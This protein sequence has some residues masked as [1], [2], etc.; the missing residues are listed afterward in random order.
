MIRS[1]A[2]IEPAD[3][4]RYTLDGD[5][6]VEN[7]IARDQQLIGKAVEDFLP[8]SLFR[9]LVLIGGYARA[10]G[11]FC[12]VDG[13]PMPY[14]DY[15]YFVVVKGANK[16]K[17]CALEPGL[18]R[19][20]QELEKQVGI[21][22][23]FFFLP[24]EELADAPCT[25]MFAE[26]QWGHAVVAGDPDVLAVMPPMPFASLPLS[27]FTR[28]MLNRGALLLMN[29]VM[30]MHGGPEDALQQEVFVKYL[31]KATLA[32][33]D[34]HLAARHI[35]HPSYPEKMRRLESMAGDEG[36]VALRDLYR[37]ALDARFHPDYG[38]YRDID[39]DEWQQ[40]VT[41]HWL[42]AMEILESARLPQP[43]CDWVS[44]ASHT[45]V[46]GQSDDT[47]TAIVRNLAVTARDYGLQELLI[48]PGWARRYPRE[49]LISVLPLLLQKGAEEHLADIC[50]VLAITEKQ[51]LE[52]CM[53]SFLLQWKRYA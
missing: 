15:D 7:R 34:A 37:L 45:V 23:D 22:V 31:F 11:G 35:Y 21:D 29:R 36:L 33:V 1:D 9:A 27:E 49:R 18:Q 40:R 39:L 43:V 28:L 25:L 53:A 26:M 6:A 5:V 41:G 2:G 32:V 46:K 10:E 47:V 17:R 12:Y 4:G 44:Y 24:E 38:K 50:R 14:N 8:A 48:R 20:A 42:H 19:V 13:K 3:N 30:R 51:T 52:H 16:A